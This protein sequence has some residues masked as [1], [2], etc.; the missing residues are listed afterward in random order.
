[1]GYH[2]VPGSQDA[3]WRGRSL[4]PSDGGRGSLCHSSPHWLRCT[5]VMKGSM[6]IED[7]GS[8]PENMVTWRIHSLDSQDTDEN[9]N[10]WKSP[11]NIYKPSLLGFHIIFQGV[12]KLLEALQSFRWKKVVSVDSE[13]FFGNDDS[14]GGNPQIQGTWNPYT[15]PNLW[16]IGTLGI[17]NSLILFRW[18]IW[19][20]AIL[21]ILTFLVGI[22][23]LPPAQKLNWRCSKVVSTHL[24]NT[25][26]NLS[27][28]AVK[29][30]LS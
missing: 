14:G 2:P 9:G 7:D 20:N 6:K 4:A 26:L 11:T 17:L 30:I 5:W 16:W 10:A 22:F 28:Q 24:W 27:Q 23:C 29:G 3:Q 1:M 15:H 8:P 12:V 13:N 25:P 18:M 19:Y 21:G